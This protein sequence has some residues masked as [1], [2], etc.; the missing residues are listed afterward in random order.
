VRPTAASPAPVRLIAMIAVKHGLPIAL[1][2]DW[3]DEEV[4]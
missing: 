2:P 4:P 3:V 1:P